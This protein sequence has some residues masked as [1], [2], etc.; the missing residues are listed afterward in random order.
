MATVVVDI[1]ADAGTT[2]TDATTEVAVFLEAAII[3]VDE[4][5]CAETTAVAAPYDAADHAE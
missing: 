5:F 4:A 1:V 2:A 3:T